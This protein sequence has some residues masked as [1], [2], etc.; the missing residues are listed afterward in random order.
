MTPAG[1]AVATHFPLACPTSGDAGLYRVVRRRRPV[2]GP[3]LPEYLTDP[4]RP[5]SRQPNCQLHFVLILVTIA[6]TVGQPAF[7]RV[8][9]A[10]EPLRHCFRCWLPPPTRARSRCGWVSTKKNQRALRGRFRVNGTRTF[11]K[12]LREAGYV[13]VQPAYDPAV[14]GPAGEDVAWKRYFRYKTSISLRCYSTAPDAAPPECRRHRAGN[15]APPTAAQRS[16]AWVPFLRR[17]RNTRYTFDRVE[18][19]DGCMVTECA[20]LRVEVVRPL[21]TLRYARPHTSDSGAG[22]GGESQ[23][24]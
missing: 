1:C 4:R 14:K 9:M 11:R 7:L 16:D 6:G 18:Y 8:I 10:P 15:E 23:C 19:R 22:A 3:G 24:R 13:M 12:G 5:A 2:V 20:R 17:S 21:N